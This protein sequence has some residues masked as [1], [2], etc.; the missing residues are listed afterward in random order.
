MPAAPIIVAAAVGS[1]VAATIGTAVVGTIVAGT[2]S[3][4]VAT[5]VGAGVI[6]AGITAAQ[7]GKVSDVLKSAVIGGVTSYIGASVAESVAGSVS[8]AA[9]AGGEASIASTMGVTAKTLGSIA[10]QTVGGGVQSALTAAVYGGD[11]IKALIKG[12][13]TAGLSSGVMTAVNYGTSKIDGFDQLP[14]SVQRATKSAL[15]AGALGKDPQQ[16]AVNSFLSSTSRYIGSQ[17]K[18]YSNELKTSYDAAQ[19]KGK[20]LEDNVARQTAIVDEHRTLADSLNADYNKVQT[21]SKE[22]NDAIAAFEKGGKTQEL[23]D[24]ANAKVKVAN[25][26]IAEYDTKYTDGKTRLDSL[27]T[28]LDTLKAQLPDQEKAF[29]ESKTALDNTTKLFQ[30]QEAKNAD[31]LAN[32]VKGLETASTT[33]KNDLGMDLTDEQIQ[34]FVE[35]GDVTAAAN[36]YINTTNQASKELGFENYKDQTAAAENDFTPEEAAQWN[37]FKDT[38][39]VVAGIAPGVETTGLG[40]Q[41]DVANLFEP[42]EFP[43]AEAAYAQQTSEQ[44]PEQLPADQQVALGV[45]EQPFQ[46]SFD[47]LYQD[48]APTAEDLGLASAAPAAPTEAPPLDIAAAQPTV[49]EEPDSVEQLLAD[50]RQNTTPSEGVQTAAYTAPGTL[51]DAGV[52]DIG[53]RSLITQ[54]QGG[55]SAASDTLGL[56]SIADRNLTP[57]TGTDLSAVTPGSATYSALTGTDPTKTITS[58]VLGEDKGD[59]R[60]GVESSALYSGTEEELAPSD[61]ISSKYVGE[62]PDEK[63]AL[64]DVGVIGSGKQA[65]TTPSDTF[66]DPV[67]LTR[68][69]LPVSSEASKTQ[70]ALE[71]TNMDE[72]EFSFDELQLP[73][74]AEPETPS[75]GAPDYGDGWIRNLTDNSQEFMTENGKVI[76]YDDGRVETYGNDGRYVMYGPD[77]RVIDYSNINDPNAKVQTFMPGANGVPSG[78]YE[79]GKF[80][81]GNKPSTGD[82]IAGAIANQFYKDPLKFLTVAGGAALGAASKPKGIQAR[83]LQSL[84]G[85]QNVGAGGGGQRVQT[86]AVGTKGRGGVRYFERKAEGGAIDGYAGGGGLGYL[87]SAHDGMADKIDATIDNKRPAK[88]SG[89]EFVIPADV[90]SHLGNGN[91]EAGAKQLYALMDRV[92]SARTGTKEQ[93]KQINPKKYLPK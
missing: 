35:S 78:T 51:T 28:E 32:T 30:E 8:A 9:A 5:A 83:G 64:E 12:G 24:I 88:L 11:P 26:F 2:V 53:L 55:T 17:L 57:T 39:G 19:A 67:S 65:T 74:G 54:Q 1:G 40:G 33:V 45:Q 16:A 71:G 79:G 59:V 21:L 3:T 77:G 47:E 87:K 37:Q 18:D 46:Y 22:A 4:A 6:S 34:Q 15:A 27:V 14:D 76:Y 58:S 41:T 73:P 90:V 42:Q 63:K 86:G 89:G 61:L 7:G 38:S 92:R 60:G 56:E 25:D 23:A 43:T 49:V 62:K 81:A 50:F 44:A 31:I 84:A 93:G 66:V 68:A 91:S 20:A 29:T 82:R 72:N 52:G 13:L 48:T 69:T 85:L 80:Y 36:D 70:T 75:G 10:G